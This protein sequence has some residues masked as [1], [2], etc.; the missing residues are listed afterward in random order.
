MPINEVL[1]E[2]LRLLEADLKQDALKEQKMR[3][4]IQAGLDDLD[5]G[6]FQTLGDRAEIALHIRNLGKRA[7]EQVGSSGE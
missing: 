4:A 6:R 1:Q 7:A 3:E 5:Q 2:G